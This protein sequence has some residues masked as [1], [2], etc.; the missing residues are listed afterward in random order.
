MR[1]REQPSNQ[2]LPSQVGGGSCLPT[3]RVRILQDAIREFGLTEDV[4]NSLPVEK[5][6]ELLSKVVDEAM[7]IRLKEYESK[8]DRDTLEKDLHNLVYHAQELDY[9]KGDYDLE[10]TQN[11]SYGH[12]R[13]RIRKSPPLQ[14]RCFV[15]TACF[16][17]CDHPYVRILRYY[18]DNCLCVSGLGRIS[19]RAYYTVGPALAWGLWRYPII[20]YAV[21][22]GIIFLA[23]W[24]AVSMLARQL[25]SLGRPD[26]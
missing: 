18:R 10:R 5:Q 14:N 1:E 23:E 17:D 22:P 16:A 21:R 13:V 12:T 4:I 6:Q 11:S 15:A 20:Q 19:I 25:S 8:V 2:K 3:S 24:L 7:R 26:R 9:T